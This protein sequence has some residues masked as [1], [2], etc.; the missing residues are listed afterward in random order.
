M[1]VSLENAEFPN[2]FGISRL[3]KVQRGSLP[4]NLSGKRTESITHPAAFSIA[5]SW[6]I[7]CIRFSGAVLL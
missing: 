7:A 5:V 3:P 2:P 4:P 6:A 1:D